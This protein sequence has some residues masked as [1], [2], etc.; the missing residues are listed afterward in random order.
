MNPDMHTLSSYVK[1]LSPENDAAD[2]ACA[3]ELFGKESVPILEYDASDMDR[4]AAEWLATN[5]TVTGVQ[6]KLSLHWQNMKDATPRLTIIGALRGDYILKSPFKDY[7]HMPELE[8]LCMSMARAC[9]I[10]TVSFGL[11]PLRSGEPCY[12]TKRID[13]SDAGKLAMEDMCQVSERLTEDKYKGSH[14]QVAKLIEQ[15]SSRPLFDIVRYYETVLFSFLIGNNDMH[16]K[17]FSLYAPEGKHVLTPAY[18]L[19]SSQLLLPTDVED[20]ALNLNGKKKK[21]NQNDFQVA[22]ST[23]LAPKIIENLFLRVLSGMQVWAELISLSII[24]E[25][26]KTGLSELIES[27]RVQLME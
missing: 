9:G 10:E 7:P 14:E 23:F 17:N 22:M 3:K 4:I 18:D 2:S 8:A 15:H 21:L 16:L 11:L 1:L 25:E 6:P 26:M 24:P 13:R 19:I 5:A 12:I 27:K 20:L